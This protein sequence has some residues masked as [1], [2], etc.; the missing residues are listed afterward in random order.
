MNREYSLSISMSL[1]MLSGFVNADIAQS[2]L[3]LQS[4]VKPNIFFLVDDSGSMDWEVLKSS[5][6][7]THYSGNR[8]SGTLDITPSENNKRELLESCVGYNVLYYNPNTTYAPWVGSDINSAVYGNASISA[9]RFNP[10][11]AGQGTTNLTLSDGAGDPS[12]YIPWN[13]ADGDG[14]FDLGEC[15]DNTDYN[16][17]GDRDAFD[18]YRN[19][20]PVS[21][22]STAQRTNFANWYSYY[23]KREYV[24]KASLLSIVTN[25]TER[26]G[27]ATLHRNS[28]VGFSVADMASSS[29]K[30]GL[31]TQIE[32]I[33]SSGG[34][35]LRSKLQQVG[36]YFE[37][38]T[39]TSLFGAS[40][41]S[42]ILSSQLGG[43]CQ[44]NFAVVMS[45]GFWNGSNPSVGNADSGGAGDTNDTDFDGG[46]YADTASNTLADVAMHYYER[47]LNS[48]LENKVPTSDLDGND[49]QHLVSYTVAFG[50]NGTLNR[51][52]NAGET[53]FNWPTPTSN[54]AT[55]IDDMRHAAWNGRGEFLS[56]SSPEALAQSLS[57]AIKSIE[58]RTASASSVA[59]NS[60]QLDTNS[61]IYQARFS[62]NTWAGGLIAFSIDQTS[63]AVGGAVWDAANLIPPEN[64]RKIY[65]STGA[66]KS[67]VVFEHG[68]LSTVQKGLIN[69]G[70]VNFIRGDRSNEG[71]VYRTRAGILGDIINSDPIYTS[72]DNF[73]YYTLEPNSNPSYA[74]YLT[75][76][77]S[78]QKGDRTD[79]IYVGANDGM[80]HALRGTGNTSANCNVQSLDCEGEEMFAY[81]PKALISELPKLTQPDYDHQYFVDGSPQYGDAYINFD[82]S[83]KRWGSALVGTLGA[84][85]KGIFALDI[86]APENFTANDVLWDLDQT[87]LPRL[88]YTFSQP[89]IARM[90][91]GKWAAIVGNGY[92][93]SAHEAVLYIIDLETGAVIKELR[94]GVFG[95]AGATN[96]LSS[97]KVADFNGD[98]II[99]AIYAGDLRGN[100]WKFDVSSSSTSNWKISFN[101]KSMY[102]ACNND[103]CNGSDY[104]PVTLQPVVIRARHGK[105][106]VLFGTG[107]YF[108]DGDNTDI[109]QIHTFY[110]IQDDGV[111]PVT[112]RKALVEQD[113]I[114]EWT[115]TQ[116]QLGND[117]RVTTNNGVKYPVQKG[118]FMDFDSGAFP[119]ERM[120]A[121][122]LARNGRIIFST[123][124]PEADPCSFGGTSWLMEMDAQSGAR[125]TVTPFDYNNDGLLNNEDWVDTDGDG[126]RDTPGSGIRSSVGITKRPGVVKD[127]SNELKYLSGSSGAIGVIRE[128]V[129]GNRGRQSWQQLK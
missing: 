119:G 101:G 93:S 13:D 124:V 98:S 6:A 20:I 15:G 45:D 97:P 62:S 19:F 10:Y 36:Q 128:S 127:G 108:E 84:G 35:P 43:S 112:G 71:S 83:G 104:Q 77:G 100:L 25:A 90:A 5:G 38:T 109:G 2:P 32:R 120:V 24:A 129:P 34:T 1:V 116:A 126:K 96:G 63:G 75:G 113:I 55:T 3:F 48:V 23:R 65:T 57:Q 79:V 81:V 85:G 91:N 72:N 54:S 67:G 4:Q 9:A 64:S 58:S 8:N 17:D 78:G 37:G 44:Q 59:T 110:G 61:R 99:D 102:T 18:L 52:P 73:G 11:T 92:H 80:L 74:A 51:G 31:L 39:S 21:S 115:A 111:S 82:G 68:N 121:A 118:W 88:G 50:V 41:S 95:S 105:P 89:T 86:S 69:V 22:M 7:N 106:I 66:T 26:M 56:A 16:G 30:E 125:L 42:P 76:K 29:D 107:K 122:P 123:L 114:F 47:D 40:R 28:S 27:L 117:I 12:G 87:D 70:Q 49:A 60:T 94:T 103:P 53:S 14:E 33:D 46:N